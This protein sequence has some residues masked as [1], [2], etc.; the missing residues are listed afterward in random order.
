MPIWAP[1]LMRKIQH[2]LLSLSPKKLAIFLVLGPLV[3]FLSYT[4]LTIGFRNISNPS[5]G[6][7]LTFQVISGMCML[8]IAILVLIWLAWSKTVV[9]H[10]TDEQLGI[11][12]KWFH[13]AFIAL[14]LFIL[15]NIGAALIEFMAENHNVIADHMH[16]INAS[17]E[18]VNFGGIMIAYPMVCHYAARAATAI[19]NKKPATFV[20]ALPFT[21]FLIFG[22]VIGVPFLHNHVSTKT[23]TN[24]ELMMTYAVAMG[25]CIMIFV[26]GLI[27]AIT[28]LI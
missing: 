26:I 17:R 3:L 11:N 19:R 25:L 21:L 20:Q 18:F 10:V 14:L 2:L 6:Q 22:T 24:S 15:F 27:A 1:S 23:S 8:L 4:M 7:T 13:I 28:G 5:N 9:A 16:L 12:R